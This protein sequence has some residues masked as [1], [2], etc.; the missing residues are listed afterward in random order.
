MMVDEADIDLVGGASAQ[1]GSRG[2]K[3]PA[4]SLSPMPQRPSKRKAGPLSR[5]ICIKRP[6]SPIPSPCPSPNMQPVIGE[7]VNRPD[8]PL[9]GPPLPPQ[10]DKEDEPGPLIIAESENDNEI[11]WVN[12]RTNNNSTDVLEPF[13]SGPTTAAEEENP[14]VAPPEAP[15]RVLVNGDVKGLIGDGHFGWK[16]AS[17]TKQLRDLFLFF[18]VPHR[19]RS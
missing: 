6:F 19:S 12:G 13:P 15:A 11:P 7:L 5:D 4:E 3:R 2:I 8:S 18:S 16:F 10:M 1:S 9:P 14:R 17:K